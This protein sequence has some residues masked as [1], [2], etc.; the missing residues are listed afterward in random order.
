MRDA[1]SALEALGLATAGP[2]WLPLLVWT[3]LASAVWLGLG[4]VGLRAHPLTHV[5]LLSATLAALPLGYLSAALVPETPLAPVV[6]VPLGA[7]FVI[8]ESAAVPP[9]HE[10]ASVAWALVGWGALTVLLGVGA[11]VGL[12]RLVGAGVGL[13]R[14]A[15]HLRPAP[16]AVQR[17]A[18]GLRREVGIRRP[19]RVRVLEASAGVRSPFV[20]GLFRPTIALPTALTGDAEAVRLVLLHELA[21]VRHG[22][23]LGMAWTALVRALFV[24]HPLVCRI[25]RSLDAARERACDAAVLA[26]PEVSPRRYGALLLAIAHGPAPRLAYAMASASPLH[27]RL[28][29]MNTRTSHRPLAPVLALLLG[30]GLA[31]VPALAQVAPER[32]A[33]P[34]PPAEA[35]PAPDAPDAPAAPEAEPLLAP[36]APPPP[37]RDW[38]T[39]EGGMQTITDR[40]QYPEMAKKAG[41]EG[42][43]NVQFR[44]MPDG[45]VRDALVSRT[46]LNVEPGQSDG[47]LREEALRVVSGLTFLPDSDRKEPVVMTIPISFVLPRGESSFDASEIRSRLRYSGVDLDR[48]VPD[49]ERAFSAWFSAFPLHIHQDEFDAFEVE[50]RYVFSEDGRA[51]EVE[52]VSGD[53]LPARLVAGLAGTMQLRP[54]LRPARGDVER[55]TL[56]VSYAAE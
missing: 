2:L 32:P 8:A 30:C 20:F 48:L 4:G 33:P 23:L 42:R 37:P 29:A 53:E 46:L 56:R 50:V 27:Q 3:V 35:P 21:H 12:V 38:P 6:S 44:V 25:G 45:T 43:V 28:L 49:S 9:P 41:I 24:A 47:G 11:A 36:P 51:T 40:L 13:V 26:S 19:V 10:A 7:V 31:A 18:D 15:R 14:L 5:R 17:Q 22:D 16:A 55:G 1:L 34:S 54:D 39:L 52:V